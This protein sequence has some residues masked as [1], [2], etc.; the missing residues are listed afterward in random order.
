MMVDC[1]VGFIK[2]LLLQRYSLAHNHQESA[3]RHHLQP[4]V[5][6][7]LESLYLPSLTHL[8]LFLFHLL[9]EH[10]LDC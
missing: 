1:V 10:L 6:P 2:P 7:K 9:A 5:L 3:E 8:L 4:Y